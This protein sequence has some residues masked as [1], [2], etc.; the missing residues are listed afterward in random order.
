MKT[1]YKAL[2]M[3]RNKSNE[4]PTFSQL[5]LQKGSAPISRSLRKCPRCCARQAYEE[6]WDTKAERPVPWGCG[7]DDGHKGLHRKQM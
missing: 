2:K 4:V 5:T 1:L 7:D 3:Y 6:Q